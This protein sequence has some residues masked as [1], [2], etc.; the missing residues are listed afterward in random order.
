VKSRRLLPPRDTNFAP[1]HGSYKCHLT[2]MAP[3]AAGIS[4]FTNSTLDATMSDTGFRPVEYQEDTGFCAHR[5][6]SGRSSSG[7]RRRGAQQQRPR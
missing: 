6:G 5:Q 3:C 7:H 2:E 4:T 1:K